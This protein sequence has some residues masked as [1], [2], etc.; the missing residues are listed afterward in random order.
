MA[1]LTRD[2]FLITPDI[3]FL[4]HGS[5]GACPK[6]IFNIYQQWQRELE[7]QPVAFLGRWYHAML[8]EARGQLADYVGCDSDELIFV[9]NATIGLNLVAR[10]LADSLN[11]S[12]GDEI[13]TTNHEYGAM[14]LM[15]DY[16]A[17]KTGAHIVRATIPNLL[18][19]DDEVVEAVWAQVTDNTRIIRISH[20][21]SPTALILPAKAICDR[22]RERGIMSVVDG[23]HVPGQLDLDLHDL[24]ADFYSGNCH[25]WLCAPKGSAFLYARNEHHTS[26]DPL[27]ISWGWQDGASFSEQNQWQGTRDIASYLTV[28]HA[29]QF[30]KQYRWHNVRGRSHAIGCYVKNEITQFTNLPPLSSDEFFAQMVSIPLPKCDIEAIKIRLHDEFHIEVPLIDH[31]GQPLVRVS[32]Q[33][34]NTLDDADALIDA[35]T[36]IFFA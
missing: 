32:F 19:E 28:P 31:H 4:N 26:L 9:P 15:W 35:I 27:V 6:H 11:L 8:D 24:G 21:T 20:I 2:D 3:I 33:A 29:I 23:A 10:S 1:Q 17:K 30:Q 5:F 22:A 7:N 16:I 12:A 25:K 34:Y 36:T 18:E 14:D 13:L